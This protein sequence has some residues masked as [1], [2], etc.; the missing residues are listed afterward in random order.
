MTLLLT[1][2]G[3]SNSDTLCLGKECDLREGR[4]SDTPLTEALGLEKDRGLV[5]GQFSGDPLSDGLG[6]GEDLGL[7]SDALDLEEARTRNSGSPL[8]SVCG[9]DNLFFCRGWSARRNN[10]ALGR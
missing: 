7:M 8:S 10:I 5:E 9:I 2:S 4:F 1:G 6:L 3:P